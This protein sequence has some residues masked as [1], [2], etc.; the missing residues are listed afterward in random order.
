MHLRQLVQLAPLLHPIPL[1]L[2]DQ[3]D[4]GGEDDES[5]PRDQRQVAFKPVELV[6]GNVA[7][8]RPVLPVCADAGVLHII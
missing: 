3:R 4:V 7:A 2:R 5:V 1:R 6:G 8:I